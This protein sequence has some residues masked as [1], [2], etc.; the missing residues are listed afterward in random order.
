MGICS[1]GA[2][3][4]DVELFYRSGFAERAG[5]GLRRAD[6]RLLCLDRIFGPDGDKERRQ[7]RLEPR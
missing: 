6:A 5:H 7:N 2:A 3:R 1:F 4:T